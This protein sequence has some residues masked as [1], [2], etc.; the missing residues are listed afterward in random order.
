MN[1]LL[2]FSPFI[3]FAV[4]MRTTSAPVALFAAAAVAIVLTARDLMQGRTIKILEMGTVL[5]F[6]ALGI[7]VTMTRGEWSIVGVRLAVDVGL[8]AIVLVSMAVRR[9]FTLQYA[10]EQVPADVAQM[11]GFIR[12][13]TIITAVWAAAF[14]VMVLA[15]VIMLYATDVPLSVG[16]VVTIAALYGAVRFTMASRSAP[17]LAPDC[18]RSRRNET[19][20]IRSHS[21]A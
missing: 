19:G 17:G 10:R 6:A 13:N 4:L 8:L 5:L 1:I 9:P 16:I 3:V 15:D 7:Y 11:P 14:A 2:S 12:T 21:L 18:R 20:R